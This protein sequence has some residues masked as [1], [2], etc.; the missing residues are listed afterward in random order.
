MDPWGTGAAIGT[1]H[2]RPVPLEFMP[3]V[4]AGSGHVLISEGVRTVTA[5]KRLFSG[6]PLSGS[7]AK[8]RGE[9]AS[10]SSA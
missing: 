2:C 1:D 8:E 5:A 10:T 7:E 3:L 4:P 6:S 9:G